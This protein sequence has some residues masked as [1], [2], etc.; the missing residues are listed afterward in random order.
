MR[1]SF[2]KILML[3]CLSM[4]VFAEI[5]NNDDISGFN[6]QPMTMPTPMN[7]GPLPLEATGQYP[8][9]MQPV[10]PMEPYHQQPYVGQQTYAQPAIPTVDTALPPLEIQLDLDFSNLMS[11]EITLE[12]QY[13]Y[14]DVR[15]MPW[16]GQAT[17]VN[18][19]NDQS[20]QI[21]RNAAISRILL[22]LRPSGAGSAECVPAGGQ[23]PVIFA[24]ISR[25]L[26]TGRTD[27]NGNAR[28][29]LQY[30]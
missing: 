1:G 11:D 6:V 22:F 25:I 9:D 3:I 5:N 17:F 18:H 28:C 12:Y 23:S 24:N 7:G 13:F 30:L 8:A 15:R 29:E 26:L 20:V 27:V 21:P 16:K 19:S 4:P 10:Q 14:T 2:K